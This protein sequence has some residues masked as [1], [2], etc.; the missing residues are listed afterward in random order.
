VGNSEGAPEAVT[1]YIRNVAEV[2]V[3]CKMSKWS[4]GRRPNFT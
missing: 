3:A 4:H 2:C 1:C